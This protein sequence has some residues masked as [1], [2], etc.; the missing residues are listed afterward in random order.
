M[1]DRLYRLFLTF[2]AKKYVA[3][4]VSVALL[5]FG[6]IAGSEWCLLTAAIFT[7]DYYS[8]KELA[9]NKGAE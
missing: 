7:I 8:K 3:W 5:W 1:R 2:I 9:V 4:A 6:K